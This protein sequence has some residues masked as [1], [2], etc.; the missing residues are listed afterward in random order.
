MQG[1]RIGSSDDTLS[2]GVLYGQGVANCQLA[3]LTENHLLDDAWEAPHIIT[4]CILHAAD[5]KT[6]GASLCRS[7]NTV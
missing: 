5:N 1:L 4:P 3:A 7:R 2:E 6:F